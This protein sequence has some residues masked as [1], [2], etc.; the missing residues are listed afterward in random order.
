M[1]QQSGFTLI[2][3]MIVIAIISTLAAIA[4]P[5]YQ[6]YV[7]KAQYTRA[8]HELSAYKDIYSMAILEGKQAILPSVVPR[9]KDE[10]KFYPIGLSVGTNI[11]NET[12]TN[13]MRTNLAKNIGIYEANYTNPKTGYTHEEGIFI[14]FGNKASQAI[15]NQF[16]GI[17]R[18]KDGV[19]FC[20]ITKEPDSL[21]INPD[22]VP[23][24]C[25]VNNRT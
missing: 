6:N 3:L 20:R 24:G 18:T 13:K 15:E 11:W 25:I 19:W 23:A 21:P 4:M 5:M 8:Y 12:N 14:I 17:Y 2:E 9:G 16:F 1:K 7:I 22:L 10:N